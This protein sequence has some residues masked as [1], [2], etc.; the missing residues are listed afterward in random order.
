MINRKYIEFN[1]VKCDKELKVRN[2]YYK[3]H[4]KQCVSCGKKNNTFAKKH[5]FYKE[6]LYKIWIGLSHRRYGTYKPKICKSW[7]TFENF[8][9]WSLSNGYTNK[10]TIDRIN[11]SKDY[12]PKNCQWITLQENAAKDKIIFTDTK[13]IQITN[14]RKLLGITQRQMAKKLNVS[15][16]TIQRAE[17]FTKSI[18]HE[19]AITNSN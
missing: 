16:N 17:K 5:G 13:K 8:K 11:N 9:N 2:D 4:S 7:Q 19:R 15:R 3:Y 10:L 1:C 6:R 12:S 18:K 14:E